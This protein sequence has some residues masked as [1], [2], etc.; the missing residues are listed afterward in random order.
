VLAKENLGGAMLAFL[1]PVAD[2]RILM[3][4]VICLFLQLIGLFIE[5]LPA[6]LI[7][8]PPLAQLAIGAGIDPVHF[9]VVL[10]INL[11]IGMLTPPVGMLMYVTTGLARCSVGEYV[12]E[13]IPFYI[14]LMLLV[15]TVVAFPETVLYLPRV[16]LGY[17]G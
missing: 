1:G 4:L 15:L 13:L 9:G 3:L 10:V 14:A 7:F 17:G 6:L 11:L 12:R 16:V 8:T 2:S 5:S